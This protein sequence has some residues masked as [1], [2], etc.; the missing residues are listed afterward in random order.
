MD[1]QII[2]GGVEHVAERMASFESVDVDDI[3]ARTITVDQ[4]TALRSIELL[5]DV[6]AAIA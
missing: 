1:S 6:R 4:P 3:V 5:A 2:A